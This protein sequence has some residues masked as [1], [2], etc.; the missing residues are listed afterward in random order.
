MS[1]FWEREGDRQSMS[2][3]GAERK[4]D[5]ESKAGSRLW[6]VTTESN[7]GLEAMDDEIMTWAEVRR[8]TDWA[9]QGPWEG[10]FCKFHI[11]FV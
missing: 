3:K 8:L 11:V 7:V 2:G 5:T 10:G 9:T 4:G 6:A 1:T